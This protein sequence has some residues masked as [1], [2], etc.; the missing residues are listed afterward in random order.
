MSENTEK[1]NPIAN[2]IIKN[3]MIWSMGAGFIPVPN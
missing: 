2:S 1:N 3:H